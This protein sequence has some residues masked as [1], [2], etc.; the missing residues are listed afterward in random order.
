MLSHLFDS[1]LQ[2]PG[3]NAPDE[4]ISSFWLRYICHDVRHEPFD[5][6]YVDESAGLGLS[7]DGALIWGNVWNAAVTML[8]T[9]HLNELLFPLACKLEACSHV[10]SSWTSLITGKRLKMSSIRHSLKN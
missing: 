10:F 7:R 9:V 4:S 5:R 6:L 8:M 2:D 1:A 3:S